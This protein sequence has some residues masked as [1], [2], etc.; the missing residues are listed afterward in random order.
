MAIDPHHFELAQHRTAVR[1]DAGADP[2]DNRLEIQG[3]HLFRGVL[4][5]HRGIVGSDIHVTLEHID[6]PDIVPPRGRRF[7]QTTGGIES[8]VA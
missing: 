1:G 2:R 7:Q 3:F 6:N 8:A 4:V 5:G